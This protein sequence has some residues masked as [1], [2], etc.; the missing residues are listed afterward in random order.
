MITVDCRDIEPIRHEL[1]VYVADNVGAIPALKLH[2]FVLSPVDE[3]E[4]VP[5]EEVVAAI[6]EF[7][8]SIGEARNFAVI[9]Q[10]DVIT[11]RSVS[12]KTIQRDSAAPKEGDGMFVCTHCGF[13]TR[14]DVEYQNHVKIHYL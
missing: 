14:Y 8:D 6:R 4:P 7:L 5:S 1:L 10:G 2:E 11:V 12:G 3:S 9:T 13:V